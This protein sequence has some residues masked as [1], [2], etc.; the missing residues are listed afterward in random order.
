MNFDMSEM[1]DIRPGIHSTVERGEPIEI[2]WPSRYFFE[3]K[4]A[5]SRRKSGFRPSC[6]FEYNWAATGSD[7]PSRVPD[8]LRTPTGGLPSM[9]SEGQLGARHYRHHHAKPNFEWVSVAF[10]IPVLYTGSLWF[11]FLISSGNRVVVSEQ[12]KPHCIV[13]MGSSSN[14]FPRGQHFL[15]DVT[16]SRDIQYLGHSR[17][18]NVGRAFTFDPNVVLPLI[19]PTG[20][21]RN[22]YPMRSEPEGTRGNSIA[23]GHKIRYRNIANNTA[24]TSRRMHERRGDEVPQQLRRAHRLTGPAP[25]QPL[26]GFTV[27]QFKARYG[28]GGYHFQH[29]HSFDLEE[30]WTER[31][32]RAS[33]TERLQG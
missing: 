1:T 14:Q 22:F 27:N 32:Y 6:N 16:Y 24:R 29:H 25:D 26:N 31:I 4:S 3:F 30:V 23:H 15:N 11:K 8:D 18:L 9:L 12:G 28:G 33:R 19:T 5:F 7:G 10:Q 21:V 2:L 13:L 17:T 20:I